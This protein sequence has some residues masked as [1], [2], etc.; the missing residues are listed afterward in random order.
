LCGW[1]LVAFLVADV[2]DDDVV[3]VVVANNKT[4]EKHILIAY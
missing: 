4:A 1:L 2:V 3:V